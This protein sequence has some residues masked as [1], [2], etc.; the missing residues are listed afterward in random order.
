[1][2]TVKELKDILILCDEDL[3]VVFADGKPVVVVHCTRDAVI[4]SDEVTI[5]NVT[6][7]VIMYVSP[8]DGL[9]HPDLTA[10]SSFNREDK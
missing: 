8:D 3:E 5:G 6:Y 2:M 9:I 10:N 4:I 1:M 7:E